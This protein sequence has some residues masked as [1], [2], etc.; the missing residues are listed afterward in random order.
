[1]F[2]PCSDSQTAPAATERAL[3]LTSSHA[4]DANVL[5]NSESWRDV[6]PGCGS[7]NPGI[8][9]SE[10]LETRLAESNKYAFQMTWSSQADID[11]RYTQL[12]DTQH[13]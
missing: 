8:P 1:M 6:H 5:I 7:H 11:P 10:L 13:L 4:D 9:R 2:H 3:T 12:T